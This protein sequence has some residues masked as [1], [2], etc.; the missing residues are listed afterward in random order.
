[1]Q[2]TSDLVGRLVAGHLPDKPWRQY[3]EY[4]IRQMPDIGRS[5]KRATTVDAASEIDRRLERIAANPERVTSVLL[6]SREEAQS[7][8]QRVDAIQIL[9]FHYAQTITPANPERHLG[10]HGDVLDLLAAEANPGETLG[11]V[12]REVLCL[13]VGMTRSGRG[14]GRH[15]RHQAISMAAEHVLEI[16]KSVT[17]NLPGVSVIPGGPIKGLAVDFLKHCLGLLGLSV[18]DGTIRRLIDSYRASRL[19]GISPCS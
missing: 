15:H 6:G 13:R 7:V 10:I 18:S 2:A 14:G 12:T 4:Q 8:I 9:L 17:G 1:M 5:L 3:V 16:Y 19:S 11:Q